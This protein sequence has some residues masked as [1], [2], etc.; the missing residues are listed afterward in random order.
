MSK[1]SVI[2]FQIELI[3]PDTWSQSQPDRDCIPSQS[4]R[5]RFSPISSKADMPS[6]NALVILAIISG[7][8][9]TISAIICGRLLIKAV[10]SSSPA[11]AISGIFSSRAPE[12][13]VMISGRTDTIVWMI[14]G[15]CS[16]SDPSSFTPV[17]AILGISPSQVER[18]PSITSGAASRSTGIASSTPSASPSI[19]WRAASFKSSALSIT[20]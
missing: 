4:P 7:I 16:T 1:K 6:A 11:P 17:C 3:Q 2:P 13:E 20:A 8:A 12:I 10:N 18:R 19:R 15:R 5:T 14:S 9:S